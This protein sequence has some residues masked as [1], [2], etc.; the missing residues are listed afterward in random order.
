[1]EASEPRQPAQAKPGKVL[2]TKEERSLIAKEAAQRRWAKAKQE[3]TRQAKAKQGASKKLPAKK[4]SAGPRE[5]SS[6][7]KMAEK[8]LAKAIQ[9]RAEAGAKYAV[10]SAE[11]P[12]LQRIIAALSHPGFE[13]AMVPHISLEQIVGDQPLPYMNPSQPRPVPMPAAAHP[14]TSQSRAMGGAIGVELQEEDNDNKFLETSGVADG[15]W[16]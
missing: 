9:E 6:A 5:F 12:S 16:H 13:T 14:V 8:R 3:K 7:L 4:R 2:H 10:L 15:Q 11:I 1:M